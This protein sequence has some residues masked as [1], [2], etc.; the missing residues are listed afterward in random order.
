MDTNKPLSL[1]LVAILAASI[2]TVV[3]ITS[4]PLQR[5]S[6]Q[7]VTI[8]TSADDHGGRFFGG[9]LQVIIEDESTDDDDDE[10][11][12]EI[13]AEEDGGN[14]G[15]QTFTIPD[16]NDGSQRFEFFL[17]HQDGDDQAPA[18]AENN[19]PV[20]IDFGAGA[21]NLTVTGFDEFDSGSIEIRYDDEIVN[22]DYDESSGEISVDRDAPY[23][24]AA[25]V[26]LMITD[27]DANL[28]PTTADS[29][30]VT[31]GEV[32]DILD[33]TGGAIVDAALFEETGDNTAIFEAE[34][35]LNTTDSATTPELDFSETVVSVELT[36]HVD[37]ENPGDAENTSTDTDTL[38]FEIDDDD[39]SM[40]QITS[41]T[42][43]SEL[44]VV[45]R[46]DDQNVDSQNEDTI[47][48]ALRVDAQNDT[49][50][51]NLEETG[52]NTG[53]FEFDLSNGELRITFCDDDD[54]T[55]PEDDNGILELDSEDIEED[56]V[57]A[58]LDPQADD[59]ADDGSAVVERT[60][61]M[62]LVP[63]TLSAPETAGVNDEFTVT[64]TDNDLND[65]PRSRDSYTLELVET[66]PHPLIRA[67]DE[68]EELY[69]F[70]I[71]IDGEAVD[72]GAAPA[73][74]EITITETGVNTGIFE[75]D[76]D[77]QDISDFGNN[78]A[79]LVIDDGSDVEIS[80][81]DF[82][83]DV[84]DADE[85]DVSIT[86]GKPNV[87]VDFSRTTVPI[88]PED[89]S[90][91]EAALGTGVVVVTM[92]VTDPQLATQSSVEETF[93]LVFGDAAGEFILEIEGDDVN[94]LTIDDSDDL[95]GA[96]GNC[97]GSGTEAE[98]VDGETLCDILEWADETELQD[99]LEE[100]GES[101]GVFEVELEFSLDG[102][103]VEASDMQDA[104]FTWTY[105][106]DEAD[107]ES[108]G[109]T[110]RGN[111]A[112]VTVDQSSAKSGTE[113]TITVEDQDL[114]LDDGETEQ[115]DSANTGLLVIET[116]DDDIGGVDHDTFDETGDDTGIFKAT[117]V[118]GEDIPLVNVVN[119]D[120]ASNILI[121][122]DDEVD[123][124]GGGGD[125]IEVNV[126]VVSST[127]SIQVTPELV[128]PATT[129]TVLIV[130]ADLDEDANSIDEYVEAD[131]DEAVEFSSS[132]SEV[133]E[134]VPDIEET[135]P[136][137][138]VF[139]F[140]LELVTDEQACADD[141]LDGA[142]FEATGG[143]TESSIGACPGDLIAIRYEDEKTGGGGS[144]TVSE[145]IEVMSW[146]P[147]FVADQDSYA[148]GDRVTITISDPDA[149]R[150]PD[151]A[152]S[153]TDIRVRSDSD[154]VGEEL[155]AIE[156]GRD[157]G[158]FRLS[159]GTTSGTAGGAISVRQGDDITVTYTD[160]FP[161][162]FVDEEEDKDF[163]FTVSVGGG[164]GGSATVTPPEP[165]D[166]TGE[167]LD[168]VSVGQQ[169]VLTTNVVN[170]EASPQSFVALI[171]VRDSNGV[172]V[173]LAWQTG[174]LSANGQ[175]QV[176]LSWTPDIADDYEVRTFV[177]SD[178][179]NPTILS[180]VET[181]N[182]TVN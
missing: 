159:F 83:A 21:T 105:H 138:G 182:I 72:F 18:D 178:L 146:D 16:T 167:T 5:A 119:N 175:T 86:I 50:T 79:A 34:L 27:Q 118:V 98:L 120:Q 147:E 88:P 155:S 7:D 29:F 71:E 80:I 179:N 63:G 174:T 28:D 99:L 45:V 117:F 75:F 85:D 136:N 41:L 115:F 36:D 69:T 52:D 137:T 162:D 127:G 181:S 153:L 124:T 131:L 110:F 70:D 163:Q 46:D 14:E 164:V 9:M 149:N 108:G 66:G 111:D 102:T 40:D 23:G 31:T 30:N 64:L 73:E 132:R 130:D 145:V 32:D 43:S 172:T 139:M 106:D 81:D 15:S 157:T 121:T 19:T 101:T 142:E 126:P 103:G 170:T 125:E 44:V 168:E 161:A 60:L 166:V 116:E 74:I 55:C 109:F 26:R 11:Q 35:Q 100:T 13:T 12:V 180:P 17:V 25:I 61:A 140:E 90:V 93:D 6:A 144:G 160:E 114:N 165:K 97:D 112:V 57:V 39:G 128:G 123:S 158:V 89:G 133:N 3:G 1:F 107:E 77:M 48:N 67:G 24:T 51:V 54:T 94:D 143:D 171:E 135:G 91:T 22:I 42:F 76:F 53:V 2:F 113:L 151:I 38:T 154:Q 56:I 150:D 129:I 134:A 10:I 177:I 122:Y 104:E 65:N 47:V 59:D 8:E 58:Y 95:F 96:D 49:E 87:S 68:L 84:N 20:V 156:T 92:I 169:V 173:F 37:Y 148:V 4:M 82:M 78:G 152:D 141:E 176:G 33:I 62:A